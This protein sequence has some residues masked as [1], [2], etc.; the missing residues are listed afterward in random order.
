MTTSDM[1][2]QLHEKLNISIEEVGRPH[3]ISTKG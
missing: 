2:I 1:V 3:K